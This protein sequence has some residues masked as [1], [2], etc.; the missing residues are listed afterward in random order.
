MT[1][2]AVAAIG[3]KN[4]GLKPNHA[5]KPRQPEVLADDAAS[6]SAQSFMDFV[7]LSVRRCSGVCA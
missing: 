1:I 5:R 7:I 6:A 4:A 2:I 3:M